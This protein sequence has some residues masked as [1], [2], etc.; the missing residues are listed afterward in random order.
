VGDEV[1]VKICGY[2]C[3]ILPEVVNDELEKSEPMSNLLEILILFNTR[4]DAVI[5]VVFIL[6]TVILVAIILC[7][8]EPPITES[9]PV[10]ILLLLTVPKIAIPEICRLVVDIFVDRTCVANRLVVVCVVL[11]NNGTVKL[12][13]QCSIPVLRLLL[14]TVPKILVV[15]TIRLFDV[16]E[17]AVT[18]LSDDKELECIFP[19]LKLLLETVPKIVLFRTDRLDV[20]TL[21]V[22]MLEVVMLELSKFV[23]IIFGTVVFD[24][25]KLFAVILVIVVFC[26]FVVLLTDRLPVLRLLELIVVCILIPDIRKVAELIF[27]VKKFVFVIFVLRR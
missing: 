12:L 13:L 21:V 14:L 22:I 10:L 2:I 16:M 18:K 17:V 3:N 7:R 1:S 5:D 20:V 8:V 27:C 26:K 9:D 24:I 19:V 6:G 25:I 4:L 11:D 23:L 15:D